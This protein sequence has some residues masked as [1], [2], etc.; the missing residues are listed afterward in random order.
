MCWGKI[1]SSHSQHDC[2]SAPVH[3]RPLLTVV[4][5]HQLFVSSVYSMGISLVPASRC[6][7]PRDTMIGQEFLKVLL[8]STLKHRRGLAR[9]LLSSKTEIRA[10]MVMARRVSYRIVR[11]LR[12]LLPLPI[13]MAL[14]VA[15]GP[16]ATVD[17]VPG[18]ATG[19]PPMPV[20]QDTN[21]YTAGPRRAVPAAD[22]PVPY[23]P[24]ACA[25]P[26]LC[27]RT[28]ASRP[29]GDD[30]RVLARVVVP[31]RRGWAGRERERCTHGGHGPCRRR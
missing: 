27:T 9:P 16:L 22:T 13:L 14:P 2:A 26:P 30:A 5:I 21:Q 18:V 7:S 31:G 24:H 23:V 20:E 12:Q 3:A 25:P 1:N 29:A 10:L 15:A 6:P 17:V 28:H 11:L 4:G 19:D 8:R